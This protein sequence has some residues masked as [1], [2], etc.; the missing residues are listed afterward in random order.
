MNEIDLLAGDLAPCIHLHTLCRQWKIAGLQ[1]ASQQ[2]H[3]C[4]ICSVLKGRKIPVVSLLAILQAC[5]AAGV[6]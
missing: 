6:G 3:E 5:P 1:P 2:I 4:K